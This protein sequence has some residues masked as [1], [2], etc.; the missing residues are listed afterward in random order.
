MIQFYLLIIFIP[1]ICKTI[2]PVCIDLHLVILLLL[3]DIFIERDE[4]LG[5]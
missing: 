4:Y 2:L 5:Y 3:E 1:D